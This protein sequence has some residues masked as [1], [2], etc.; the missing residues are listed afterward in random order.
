[1]SYEGAKAKHLHYIG[2]DPPAGIAVWCSEKK[3]F[4]QIAT[5]DFWGVVDLVDSLAAAGPTMVIIEDPGKNKPIFYKPGVS[6]AKAASRIA[7]NVGA[8]KQTARALIEFLKKKN[9]PY[10]AVAPLKGFL[11]TWKN[12]R[13][14]FEQMTNFKSETS[15]HGR[16]AAALVFG[17]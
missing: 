3:K 16:D 10:K 15:E 11:K 4:H 1:M 7:Q 6:N 17:R 14:Q 13:E 5:T 2:I 9:I 12:N 8:N